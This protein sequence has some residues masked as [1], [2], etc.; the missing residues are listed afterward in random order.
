MKRNQKKGGG[1]GKKEN[2]LGKIMNTI[3]L[4]VSVDL[5]SVI[6]IKGSS[7]F[8]QHPLEVIGLGLSTF[9]NLKKKKGGGG[10]EKNKRNCC[11]GS[12]GGERKEKKPT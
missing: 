3:R 6:E 8:L 11:E 7:W 12:C 2:L 4:S 5:I 1:G 9:I 10:Q